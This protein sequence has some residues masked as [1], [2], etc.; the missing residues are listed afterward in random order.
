MAEQK[1]SIKASTLSFNT[2]K[3]VSDEFTV[4]VPLIYVSNQNTTYVKTVVPEEES[5]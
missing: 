5:T 3:R 2:D 1:F 4:E